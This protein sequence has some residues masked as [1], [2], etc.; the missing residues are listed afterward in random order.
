MER[1]S[2]CRTVERW[3]FNIGAV[4][5][6][7]CLVLAGLTLAFGLKPLIFSS[8]SMG[9]AIPTGSL[10]LA[11]PAA[12]SDV[13]PGEVVSVV[14]SDG[15][16]IT[17]RVVSADPSMGL[18]LKGDANAVADLQP[19]TGAAVDRI[20]FSIPS[21]G[22]VASWLASPW[23]FLLGG[24]LCA[25]LIYVAFFRAGSGGA[26]KSRSG[27]GRGKNAADGE[28]AKPGNRRRTWL[29]IGAMAAVIAVAVPLGVAAKVEPTL[30]V[31]TASAAAGSE[32]GATAA[33]PVI[34]ATCG[35]LG[36]KNT[37]EFKWQKPAS[38][39]TEYLVTAVQ[40]NSSGVVTIGG[41]VNS[42]KISGSSTSLVTSNSGPTGLLGTLL[43]ALLG[44]NYYFTISIT[45]LHGDSWASQPVV[46]K[47]VNTTAPTLIILGEL[48]V[49]CPPLP[50]N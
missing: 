14:S 17:H 22:Y 16:R 46:F 7:L 2:W 6:A 48:K 33:G 23:V 27:R 19:Y 3:L 38:T 31:W 49:T 21:L 5:G 18:V 41:K 50:T 45:A 20:L 25:Y 32:I 35:N 28:A 30:A 47:G 39:P 44:Y 29:G 8:G 15:T 34:G 1:K 40:T 9:P 11:L 26:R 24:L 13:S 43:G 4:L 12:V 42:E 10:A 36:D 37:I